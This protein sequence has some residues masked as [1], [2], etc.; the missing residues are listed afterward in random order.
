VDLVHEPPLE[1][2]PAFINTSNPSM[3]MVNMNGISKGKLEANEGSDD[4]PSSK[5]KS[6]TY[7]YSVFKMIIL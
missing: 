1:P 6:S 4:S 3:E 2:K 7:Y 5:R